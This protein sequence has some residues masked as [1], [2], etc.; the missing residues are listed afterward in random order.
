MQRDVAIA[1]VG[2]HP[3]GRYPEKRMQEIGAVAIKNALDDAKIK[4]PEI[5]GIVAGAYHWDHVYG[6]MYGLLGANALSM[7]F[8]ELN[9]PVYNIANACATGVSAISVGYMMIASGLHDMVLVVA[10]D[11]SGLGFFPPKSRDKHDTDYVRYTMTGETN[12]AYWAMELRRRWWELGINTNKNEKLLAAPKVMLSQ[13]GALNPNARY[14]RRFT[15]EEV[16][17]SPMVAD[18]LKLYMICATSDGAA[19]MILTTLEKA[20]KMTDKPVLIEGATCVSSKF[21][22]PCVKLPTMS[23]YPRP[24]VPRLS[25]ARQAANRV[26]KLSGRKPEEVDV[27]EEPDHSPWHYLDYLEAVLQIPENEKG[28]SEKM[29]ER[30]E[31]SPSTGRLPVC[32]SGGTSSFGEVLTA[33]GIMRVCELVWQL[34]RQAGERQVI[35]DLKVGFAITYGYMGNNAACI[36][37]KA[38]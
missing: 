17:N 3:W 22:E 2:L 5:D 15:V 24:G 25:D 6:G 18:P 32:P 30:G 28:T 35:K 33:D 8:G 20:K 4:W 16:L 14:R 10:A 21:G 29:L 7:T 34:R 19:A 13:A 38:W 12:P 27:I 1:G 36:V 31:T 9:I 23:S 26:Y 11:K 37:S